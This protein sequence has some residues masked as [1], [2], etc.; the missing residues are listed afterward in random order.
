MGVGQVRVLTLELDVD[1]S[2]TLYRLKQG[3]TLQFR[4]APSL[5][6]K[7][8]QVWT[9]C[10]EQHEDYERF[11]YKTLK[12]ESDSACKSDDTAIYANV[13]LTTSGSF[14]YYLTDEK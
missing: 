6:G 1:G 3:W 5:L 4:L 14:H 7:A 9:N 13:H 10:P 2:K 8:V 11:S 12:W